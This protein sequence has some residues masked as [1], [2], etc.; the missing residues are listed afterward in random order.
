M[1]LL[2]HGLGKLEAVGVELRNVGIKIKRPVYRQKFG[3]PDFRQPFNQDS[4]VL[5][6]TVLDNIHFRATIERGFSRDLRQRRYGYRQVL[7]QRLDR[8]HQHFRHNDPAH[9]P[10]GHAEVLRE[11]IDDD[12]LG[13]K[14]GGRHRR[15]RV[16]EPV[17]DLIRD[18]A[19]ACA[20][21]CGDQVRHGLT[22]HHGA[23]RVCGTGDQHTLQ[24][25]L[26][27]GLQQH[28]SGES[29]PCGIGRFDQNGLTSEGTQNV[30]IRR[31][32]GRRDGN[33]IA[34]LERRQKR[35]HKGSRRT[36]GDDDAPGIDVLLVGFA[37]VACDSLT[38]RGDA[39]SGGI[40]DLPDI[41]GCARSR[42]RGLRRGSRRLA[43]LHMDHVAALGLDPGGGRH[44]IHHHERRN[45]AAAG[46]CQKAF[47]L[48]C[49]RHIQCPESEVR[50][51]CITLHSEL[52]IQKDT[53][54]LQF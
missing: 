10:T 29:V 37:V 14:L 43:N 9:A 47:C 48:V 21:R 49:K 19:D 15:K 50:L 34:G 52:R 32:A 51:V 4:P 46:G 6:I 8:T 3:Q 12:R 26:A 35:E 27:V 7:L 25:C 53:G 40:I 28:L 23:G 31:I 54:K 17:I 22:R 16:V 11:R 18:E 39:D 36:R 1:R 13:R 45:I 38:Q 24:R 30:P 33:T 44:H 5:L 41:Q 20:V 42:D 2:Q